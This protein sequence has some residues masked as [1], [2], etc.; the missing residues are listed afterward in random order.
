MIMIIEATTVFKIKALS[1]ASLVMIV[2]IQ[3]NKIIKK[4]LH[5][6]DVKAVA[7]M[8]LKENT[9]QMKNAAQFEI[10]M[11]AASNWIK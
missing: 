5:T 10:G 3:S 7:I 2:A 1:V 6:T 11:R 9:V 4:H 8:I